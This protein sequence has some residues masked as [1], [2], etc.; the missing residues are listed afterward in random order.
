MA[1]FNF[2]EVDNYAS[3]GRTNYFSLKNDKDTAKV[4]FLYSTIDDVRGYAVYRVK[5]GDRERYVNSLRAYNDPIEKDPF[6][7]AG[8]P[9]VAKMFIP[10][11]NIDAGEVQLWERGRTFF[12]RIASMASRYNPLYSQIIEIER[13]GAKGDT[14]TDYAMYPIEK[15]DFDIDSVDIPNP[16]G[17]IILDKTFEEMEYYVQ[18]GEFPGGSEQVAQRRQSQN[19]TSSANEDVPFEGSTPVRRTPEGRRAF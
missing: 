6:A 16:L 15:S 5:V 12:S 7:M 14:R 13:N 19:W 1:T 10:V 2:N 18:H 9:V 8:Y 17:T 4:R 3:S 11:Y